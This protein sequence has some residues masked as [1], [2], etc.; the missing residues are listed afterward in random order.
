MDARFNSY[1]NCVELISSLPVSG[2]WPLLVFFSS[3]SK[4]LDVARSLQQGRDGEDGHKPTYANIERSLNHMLFRAR[5][6]GLQH[7]AMP[8]IAC[9]LDGKKWP[10]IREILDRVTPSDIEVVVCRLK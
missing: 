8:E 6:L 7:I 4:S 2:L 1:L 3:P 10:K 9:G 5:K